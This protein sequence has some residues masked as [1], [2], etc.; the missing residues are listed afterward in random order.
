MANCPY[1]NQSKS[2]PSNGWY[3][4][5]AGRYVGYDL[6]HY[7]CNSCVQCEKC[8][9]Y[10]PDRARREQEK[11]ERYEREQREKEAA[12]RIR[13]QEDRERTRREAQYSSYQAPSYTP[14]YTPTYT[15]GGGGGG[16]G[17]GC[18]DQLFGGL[19]AVLFGGFVLLILGAVLLSKLGFFR[20]DI[21]LQLALPAGV[22][23]RHFTMEVI[24]HEPDED[25]KVDTDKVDKE[26]S[27]KIRMEVGMNSAYLIYDDVK[28][29][30]SGDAL[31]GEAAAA[32]EL[33]Y[34]QIRDQLC[35]MVLVDLKNMAEEPII[36]GGVTVTDDS[37]N[38]MQWMIVGE[39]R[40]ALVIPEEWT[41]RAATIAVDGYKPFAIAVAGKDRLTGVDLRLEPK[42]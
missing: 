20:E 6:Y 2:G 33:E 34:A 39:S 18:M 12:A 4:D 29:S 23:P 28:F 19:I 8:P 16:G 21:Q 1:V 36:V 3:C 37:G 7:Y 38:A 42:E 22:N 40:I 10:D 26:G 11:K 13:E 27:A 41:G 31:N 30:L 5:K 17:L 15:G 9:I 35:R 24:S 25:Y 32:V 14:T